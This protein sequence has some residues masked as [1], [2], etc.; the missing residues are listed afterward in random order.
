MHVQK[1]NKQTK[2]KKITKSYFLILH[3]FGVDLRYIKFLK[4]KLSYINFC[5]Q[6]E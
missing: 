6:R 3:L 4:S 5:K 2:N 1:K